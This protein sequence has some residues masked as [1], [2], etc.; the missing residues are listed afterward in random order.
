MQEDIVAKSQEAENNIDKDIALLKT[1]I[2]N[3]I[4]LN[5]SNKSYKTYYQLASEFWNLKDG[6]EKILTR[7]NNSSEYTK[8]ILLNKYPMIF[9]K[10]RLDTCNK[11]ITNYNLIYHK[12][13]T[14]QLL[15]KQN[16]QLGLKIPSVEF[17]IPLRE[18]IDDSRNK[19][20]SQE[21]KKT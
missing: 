20:N 21:N 19:K 17:K 7:W 14:L 9:N 1:S 4:K 3:N 15:I 5:W 13:K 8:K 18:E 6:A 2:K 12:L 11:I 16:P 10:N